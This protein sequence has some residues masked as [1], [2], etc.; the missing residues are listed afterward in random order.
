MKPNVWYILYTAE[1]FSVLPASGHQHILCNIKGWTAEQ[2]QPGLTPWRLISVTVSEST[3]PHR[4]LRLVG[5]VMYWRS[6]AVFSLTHLF[7]SRKNFFYIFQ[8]NS[9]LNLFQWELGNAGTEFDIWSG[10]RSLTVW[11]VSG[12]GVA[13]SMMAAARPG[14]SLWC[15]AAIDFGVKAVPVIWCKIWGPVV[16]RAKNSYYSKTI[17]SKQSRGVIIW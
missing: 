16:F 1:L 12:V 17:G 14:T 13:P 3:G 11:S 10:L 2:S 5:G 7:S 8:L 4:M 6:L 15:H 9:S